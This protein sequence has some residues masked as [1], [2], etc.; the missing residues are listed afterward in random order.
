MRVGEQTF[1]LARTTSAGLGGGAMAGA[2]TVPPEAWLGTDATS[3]I[4]E[5]LRQNELAFR[6][7]VALSVAV[8]ALVIATMFLG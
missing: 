7:F 2:P 6:L 1:G 4:R 5:I 3:E 8:C